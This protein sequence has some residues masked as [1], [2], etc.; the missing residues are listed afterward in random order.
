[1]TFGGNGLV[2][3]KGCHLVGM[4]LSLLQGHSHQRSHLCSYKAIPTKGHTFALTMPFPP[5]VTYLLLQGHSHQRS[6]LYSYNAIPTK[7][8]IFA[9]TRP[10]PTK[11]TSLFLQGYSHQ[12]STLCS[13]KEQRD[14]LWWEWPCKSKG[15]NF[16]GNG[17]V[18]VREMC[19][20]CQ[21]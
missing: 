19:Q 7:G 1:V 10:F 9:L 2:R 18:G 12:R 21:T 11:V 5:K 8:H 16:G 6:H 17:L 15:M 4:V 20:S 14:D 3:A 13:Y